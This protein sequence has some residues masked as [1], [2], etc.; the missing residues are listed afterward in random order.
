MNRLP[1]SVENKT[2]ELCS[3]L[4][5]DPEFPALFQKVER[6]L[7]DVGAQFQLNQFQEVNQLLQHKHSMGAE[8]TGEEINHYEGLRQVV[9]GS[10]VIREFVEAQEKIQALQDGIHRFLSKTFQLGRVP[11][12]EDF[13]E[14]TCTSDCGHH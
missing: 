4:T 11:V 14:E 6:Y 12:A 3:A 7:A 10:E 13:F 5:Q 2:L 9:L 8:L 1:E